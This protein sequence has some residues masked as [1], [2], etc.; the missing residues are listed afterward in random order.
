MK[1]NLENPSSPVSCPID[2]YIFRIVEIR[3]W[4]PGPVVNEWA[5]IRSQESCKLG[6]ESDKE[7]SACRQNSFEIPE[8]KFGVIKLCHK[9]PV[10]NGVAE[11]FL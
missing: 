10:S 4:P 1:T 8:H 9:P 2:E 7:I 6:R 5:E 3:D 11:P